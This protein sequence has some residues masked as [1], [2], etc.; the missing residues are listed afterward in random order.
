MC[1]ADL[2]SGFGC[3]VLRCPDVHINVKHKM[4]MEDLRKCPCPLPIIH[5]FTKNNFKIIFEKNFFKL[6]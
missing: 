4:W 3:W 6:G 1:R 5:K 2:W